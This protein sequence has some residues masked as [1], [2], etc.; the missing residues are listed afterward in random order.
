MMLYEVK[1]LP[2]NNGESRY[3][4]R[5]APCCGGVK[6]VCYAMKQDENGKQGNEMSLLRFILQFSHCNTLQQ[7]VSHQELLSFDLL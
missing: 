6:S 3:I 4:I 7:R 2:P 1:S 5:D